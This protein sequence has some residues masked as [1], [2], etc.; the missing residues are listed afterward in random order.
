M[1]AI[2]KRNPGMEG[3]GLEEVA[4]VEPREDEVKIKV[5]ACGICGTDLHIV[6]DEYPYETPVILGHEFSGI[7]ELTGKQAN[8]FK[9]G[10]RVVS[11]TAAVTCGTCSYCRKGLI[12]LCPKRK[13]IGSG[14]NGA[15]AEYIVVPERNV[16]SLPANI[17]MDAASLTEPLACV[18]RGLMERATIQA[19]DNVLVSGCGT[20]GLLALEIANIHGASV[21]VSGTSQDKNRFEVAEILGAK[22]VVNVEEQSERDVLHL[23]GGKAFDVVIEC[24]GVE[25]SLHTCL[26]LVKKQGTFIQLGL[27]GKRVSFDFDRMLMKEVN[28]VNSF[29]TTPSSWETALTLIEQEKVDLEALITHKFSIDEWKEAFRVSFQKEGIKTIIQPNLS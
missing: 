14:V 22:A 23:N 27:F 3:V 21:I 1:K 15:M 2:V 13:S 7:V 26:S 19:G 11:L 5:S 17:S 20:I 10:D 16:L 25:S 28:Y 4:V 12:M 29:A 24:A 9:K 6:K 18:V 8:R